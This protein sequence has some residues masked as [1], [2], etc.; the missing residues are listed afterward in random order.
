MSG[1]SRRQVGQCGAQNHSSRGVGEGAR[2]ET[3]TSSEVATS[4]ATSSGKALG[5]VVACVVVVST[6]GSTGEDSEGVV[7]VG[8]DSVG[9]DSLSGG[10][11]GASCAGVPEALE[12]VAEVTAGV[13]LG[14]LL[15]GGG[16]VETW[17]LLS[18]HE[19]ATKAT[20]RKPIAAAEY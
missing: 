19:A 12:V 6:G 15:R 11:E 9:E 18:P 13:S 17:L 7:S 8:V 20:A 10:S 16:V 2:E 4:M 3:R 14:A 1:A 5:A